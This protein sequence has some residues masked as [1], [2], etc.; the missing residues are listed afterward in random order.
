MKGA[1]RLEIANTNEKETNTLIQEFAEFL[2]KM[3]RVFGVRKRYLN[4]ND[5]YENIRDYENA[6]KQIENMSTLTF[7]AEINV[8]LLT[9]RLLGCSRGLQEY[10]QN[11]TD[12]T[13]DLVHTRDE[14]QTLID[15]KPIDFFR[16]MQYNPL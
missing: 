4:E 16:H 11:S 15:Q 5:R 6:K 1:V 2:E 13:V 7:G 9:D 12:I 14:A 3:E 10:L 8:L